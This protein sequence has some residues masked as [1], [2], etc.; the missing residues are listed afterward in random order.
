MAA[1]SFYQVA[2]EVTG[3]NHFP[4][5]PSS[6]HLRIAFPDSMGRSSGEPGSLV[7]TR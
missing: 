1:F 4:Q 7:G 5:P 6:S 2:A 3:A